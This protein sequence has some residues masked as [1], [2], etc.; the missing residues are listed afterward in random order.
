MA[1]FS[2]P[3]IFSPPYSPDYNPIESMFSIFKRELKMRRLKAVLEGMHFKT[4]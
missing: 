3:C 2:I 1:E 4:N